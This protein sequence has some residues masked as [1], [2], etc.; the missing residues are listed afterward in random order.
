MLITVAWTVW[1][2]VANLKALAAAV[3]S[4]SERLSPELDRLAEASEQTADHAASLS[5]RGARLAGER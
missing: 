3:Q 4:L 5:E 2:M 1:R